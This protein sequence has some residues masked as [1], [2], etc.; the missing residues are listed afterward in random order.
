VKLSS[1]R[2][3]VKLISLSINSFQ[4]EAS[5]VISPGNEQALFK[6]RSK[7]DVIVIYDDE[8]TSYGGTDSP[9]STLFR[10]IFE[11][12]FHRPLKRP[13]MLLV[14]GLVAWKKEVD[15]ENVLRRLPST[16]TVGSF[17]GSFS[18][19]NTG[20]SSVRSSG[21]DGPI[22]RSS[23][24]SIS[25]IRSVEERYPPLDKIMPQPTG[26]AEYA[27]HLHLTLMAIA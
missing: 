14:G 11:N 18:A 19:N 10:A 24:P 7:F 25:S 16:P 9:L 23:S 22:A 5:Q 4:I 2:L 21:T 6:N 20:P 12:E 17:V 3:D 1:P 27:D 8:S 15:D 13:P 26:Y